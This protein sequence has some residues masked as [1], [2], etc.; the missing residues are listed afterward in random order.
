[1]VERFEKGAIGVIGHAIG[2]V[3]RSGAIGLVIGVVLVEA[4]GAA[5]DKSGGFSFPGGT[6]VQIAS[7][8]FG[9]ALGFAFA[10]TTALVEGVK[11]L[12][13]AARALEG[14]AQKAV[15]AGLGDVGRA[16]GSVVQGIEHKK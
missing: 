5:L 9:L 12:V 15:G 14:D 6:F 2:A 10:M 11:G 13:E 8:A 3:L 16:A 4:A 1:M 7:V